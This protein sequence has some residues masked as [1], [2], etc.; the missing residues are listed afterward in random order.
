[1]AKEPE[2]KVMIVDYGMGNVG[3]VAHALDSLDAEHVVSGMKEDVATADAYILPGVGAFPAA[4]SNL[5][6]LGLVDAL[7]EQVLGRRKPFLGIC[8]G[9]QLLVE[10]SAEQ[11]FSTG[12]GWIGGHVSAVEA[13]DDL[14]VPHV[15]W[16]NLHLKRE[17]PLFANVPEQTHLYYDH[18][19]AVRCADDVVLATCDYGAE[20]VA[21]IRRDNIVGVQ[22]HPEK[23]QRNGLRILRNFLRFAAGSRPGA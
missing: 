1:M 6:E 10:D 9:M 3:S 21:A 19:F 23:S 20:Y 12:L 8:L 2:L 5:R 11:G 4:M 17:D 7:E 22:F 14:R 13:T 16:N 18:A 15:G